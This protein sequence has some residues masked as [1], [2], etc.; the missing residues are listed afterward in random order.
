M[1]P[2]ET[3]RMLLQ[4]VLEVSICRPIHIIGSSLGGYFGTWLMESI[5]DHHPNCPVKL[6]LINPIVRPYELFEDYLGPQTNYC[7]GQTYE[8][9][10]EHINQLRH[11][12]IGTLQRPDNILLLIQTG[13][14]TLDYQQ[15]VGRYSE[16]PAQIEAGGSHAFDDFE[17]TIPAILQFFSA[18]YI[19]TEVSISECK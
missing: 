7:S 1:W 14:E 10:Q 11:L 6:V 12:E 4:Q 13:D 2:S 16:C 9:T 18:H 17:A 19:M 15:A 3:A 5:I 8:L